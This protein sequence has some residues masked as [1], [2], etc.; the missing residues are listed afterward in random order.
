MILQQV[1]FLFLFLFFLTFLKI[2]KK[3]IE[4][5]TKIKMEVKRLSKLFA[6]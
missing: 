4:Q 5:Q 2:N 1:L 6:A 3:F